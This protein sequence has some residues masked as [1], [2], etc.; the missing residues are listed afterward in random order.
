M[1]NS[2]L[3]RNASSSVGKVSSG[4]S[5][6]GAIGKGLPIFF[7]IQDAV[8]GIRQGKGV[9]ASVGKA[10]LTQMFYSTQIGQ[11]YGGA[12][13]AG[14]L[15][16]TAW[17]ATDGISRKNAFISNKAYRGQFGGYYNLSQNGYTIRQRGLNAI[18][19]SG[20]YRQQT[21][22]SEARSYYRGLNRDY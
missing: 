13:L 17:K 5:L 18:Q 7:G 16:Q 19:K 1:S 2:V 15:A 10:A 11:I 14:M 4:I 20:M 9:V 22:G 21:L 3:G 8:G 12:E 6:G